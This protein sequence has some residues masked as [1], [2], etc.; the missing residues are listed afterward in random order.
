MIKFDEATSKQVRAADPQRS[1]WLSA[2]AGSGK[3][4]VLTD[5]VARLL[6]QGVDPQ[7]ILCLTYTK[8]AASEMQNRLFERLGKWSMLDDNALTA[9]LQKLGI[10]DHL[11]TRDLSRA[12]T[13]FASA[14][15]TP[16][17][18][19][20][21]TIHS[22]CS[23]L[24][25]RFPL[26]AGL[27]PDFKEMEDR[28]AELLHEQVVEEMADGEDVTLVDGIARH[29][30]SDAL[31]DL[32]YEIVRNRAHFTNASAYE[33]LP[34]SLG[35]LNETTPQDAV[36]LAF[37]G[38]EMDVIE[39]VA[40][41]APSQSKSIQTFAAALI[42]LNIR[43]PDMGDLNVLFDKFLY[44][45]HTSKSRNFP[46]SNWTKAVEA[47]APFIEE[48]HDWMDRT[49]TAKDMLKAIS[50]LERSRALHRFAS[51]FLT[52]YDAHK[53]R[54]GMLDFDDLINLAR[55]LLTDR[56][57]AEWVLYKL[58]G[59]IDHMLVDEAQDTSPTQ[60]EVVQH[61]A[62]EFST[63]DG[64]RPDRQRTIFVVGDKKQSIYSF[65]GADPKGFD[66]MKEHF[67]TE[68]SGIGQVLQ[69]AN[70]KHSFR[71][72]PAILRMVDA[73]FFGERGKGVETEI[74]HEAFH[75]EMPG[76]I[77]L[78]PVVESVEKEDDDSEW[79]HPVDVV[80]PRHHDL[81]LARNVAENIKKMVG[82]ETL[83]YTENDVTKRRLI[84]AGDI[85]ILVQRRSDLFRH[86]IAACKAAG[87]SVAGADRLK[88]G[89][90]LA[91]KDISATLRFLALPEDDL[92]LASALKS[93]LFGWSEQQIYT[94]AHHRESGKY[95]WNELYDTAENHP[96][97]FA[98]LDDL[99]S[100]TDFL[101]PYD[102]I[103]RLLT[104]H[105]GRQALIAR[106]GVEAADGIDAL[107]GQAL[108]YERSEIPSLT[109]FLVWLEGG[110]LTVKRQLDNAGDQ[111]RVMTVHGAKGLEA[112][113]VIL[114]D[115]AKRNPENKS[116]IYTGGEVALWKTAAKEMPAIMSTL[117]DDKNE[118]GEE[119]RMRL[120]YVAMTRAESWLIICG[121]GNVGDSG[122]SWYRIVEEGM[123]RVSALDHV[124]PTGTG[125]RFS[126]FDWE[127]APL[128]PCKPALNETAEPPLNLPNIS[129]PTGGYP[130]SKTLA[131]SDLGGAK[132]LA[133]EVID[134]DPDAPL[135][136]G[137]RVHLLLE[138]LP[139]FPPEM[140]LETGR[141]LL[142]ACDDVLDGIEA[143]T[144]ITEISALLDQPHLQAIF[145]PD[146]LAEVDI[147]GTLP[148]GQRIHGAIDRLLI[149]PE[150]VLAV[151]FKSNKIVPETADKTPDG[152]L[153]QMGAYRAA[154][155]QIFPDQP[156]ETAILWT[157]NGVLMPLPD[158][159]IEDALN[160]VSP[161]DDTAN[162]T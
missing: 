14:V 103:E 71:S 135:I 36:D 17:G 19:K 137:R 139:N 73:T 31:A 53:A 131:P 46:Q 84:T 95:L 93:P 32:T 21:Q 35:L 87:L 133:G 147:T 82:N 48:L 107:L 76:R 77:D 83:T 64:V 141:K 67:E 114:P 66:R 88:I 60:W 20:I 7:N 26:E 116:Q 80:G 109:G 57:V 130:R 129:A 4:R 78:W 115:T 70:L 39:A 50:A 54:A 155:K 79:Y 112:P 24:L 149:T 113:I 96:E 61:L 72:S 3:T 110:D 63:G 62:R 75:R 151:D 81:I 126:E 37:R 90:E 29:Y 143:D 101:R 69:I 157:Q 124:H 91:V 10:S 145:S 12:R 23:S 92:S 18:L 55:D 99:R 142:G 22:F 161:L 118:A 11:A 136:H 45:D 127:S 2:N 150:R 42:S 123:T 16:G 117:K 108:A 89:T 65:Q 44:A 148:D 134:D 41:V 119:E 5:R 158:P 122:E 140:H 58:D 85:I 160:R 52:L 138:H 156:I 40:E 56:R 8:A 162:S 144:L 98:I 105:G 51:R 94:L 153:R 13:L 47:F 102:L 132:A 86:I 128:D 38:D 49:A 159:L 154:L 33:K 6:F 120:L 104:R 152:L 106:L 30:T 100:Q 15:E 43:A 68:L 111:I 34:Q 146:A 74:L 59:G 121:A 1:T 9:D 28:A 27:S 125:L 97:T 25:R